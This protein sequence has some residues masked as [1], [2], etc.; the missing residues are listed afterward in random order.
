MKLIFSYGSASPPSRC[1]PGHN[2]ASGIPPFPARKV[3]R[4][5]HL[6]IFIL[7][8]ITLA[9]H[10]STITVNSEPIFDEPAY[11][12]A[13]RSIVSGTGDTNPE[14]PPLGKLL[15]VSGILVFGDSPVG[16]RFFP[17]IFGTI[18]IV[19]FYFICLKLMPGRAAFLATLLFTMESMSF[20]MSS[21][22]LLDVFMLTL[23]M[24]GFL[25][26]LHQRYLLSGVAIALSA[27]AKL[28]GG[29]ALIAIIL[30]WL[31][32]KR[33]SPKRFVAGVI[34]VPV[35]FLLFMLPLNY[36]A[37]GEWESPLKSTLDLLSW[38]RIITFATRF[39][40]TASRPWEWIIFP[41]RMPLGTPV[42]LTIWI[43][44]IP[45]VVYMVFMARRGDDA[46]RFGLGW[47]AGTYLAWVPLSLATNRLSYPYY[48]YPTIG[49]I[50]IGIGLG[51]SQLLDMEPVKSRKAIALGVASYLLLHLAVFII[52]RGFLR[53]WLQ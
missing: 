28:T 10:F 46:A 9:L 36:L 14:H 8:I 33:D 52:S 3:L 13:A 35:S 1:S 21:L 7:V 17:V 41:D 11:V 23:M 30:H 44:I 51:L 45:A 34:A 26:Y 5:Q 31:F 32:I 24:A 53:V 42:S 48:F 39:D 20:V 29:L 6:G 47:F 4:W 50:C 16:W 40:S 19:L 25:L 2:R 43:L 18:A 27:L 37:S 38:S 49:A 12:D 22:A 15:I